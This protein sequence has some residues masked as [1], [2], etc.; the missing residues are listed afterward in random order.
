MGQWLVQLFRKF[1]PKEIEEL[2]Y[3]PYEPLTPEK[4]EE[5]KE[6]L[7]P[8]YLTLLCEAIRDFEGKPGD[9]N[10][11]NNNPGNVRYSSVGYLP[12]YGVVKRDAQNFAIFKDYET[13]WLYLKNLIIHKATTHPNWN[14]VS[15]MKEYAPAE[16]HNEPVGYATYLGKRLNVNPYTFTLKNLLA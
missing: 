3:M 15:L 4:S 14:L 5:I 1:F 2:E 11:R 10:Y 9:R 6:K 16:D 13:G 12:K 7:K 8:D